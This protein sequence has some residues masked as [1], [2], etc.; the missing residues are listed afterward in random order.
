MSRFL[1]ALLITGVATGA[2]ALIL[3]SLD[4]ESASPEL[5]D[6]VAALGFNP[7]DIPDGDAELLLKELASQL[8]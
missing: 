8:M 7:D 2:A 3:R 5:N 4:L 1:K 6:D